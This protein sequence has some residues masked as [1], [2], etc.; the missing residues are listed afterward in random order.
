VVSV[1]GAMAF[2]GE[3]ATPAVLIGGVLVIAGV[4]IAA[5]VPRRSAG[6]RPD[7]GRDR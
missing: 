2:L 6:T 1:L 4:L 5:A 3:R 7:P